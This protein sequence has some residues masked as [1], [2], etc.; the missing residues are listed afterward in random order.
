LAHPFERPSKWMSWWAGS[1]AGEKEDAA[2]SWI[3]AERRND[4]GAELV[5]P[6]EGDRGTLGVG[7]GSEGECSS[8]ATVTLVLR[9]MKCLMVNK[10][11][12]SGYRIDRIQ[13]INP[14]LGGR[15]CGLRDFTVDGNAKQ[16]KVTSN[17]NRTRCHKHILLSFSK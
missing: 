12:R 9:T 7:K 11:E 17:P 4:S 14:S 2:S 1:D 3:G 13:Q 5:L 16:K 15:T 6:K 8:D 10:E